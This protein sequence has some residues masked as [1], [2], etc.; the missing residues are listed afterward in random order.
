MTP[1]QLQAAIGCRP[2]IAVLWAKSLDNAMAMNAI[3]VPRR[4]AAFLATIG[5]ESRRL[6]RGFEDLNYTTA[7][8][9]LKIFG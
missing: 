1:E 4:Q 7:E 2:D 9:L 6:T 3:D 5:V 8:R